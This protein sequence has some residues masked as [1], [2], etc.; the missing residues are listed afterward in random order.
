MSHGGQGNQGT[1]LRDVFDILVK[2]PMERLLSLKIQLGETPED[3]IIHALC[4]IIL[5]KEAQALEKLQMLKN[6][7][8]AEHLAEKWRMSGGK[9]EDFR[10]HCGHFEEFTGESLAA[11]ARIFKVLHERK[12]CDPNL[13]NLAYQRALSTDSQRTSH[14]EDLEYDPLR[15][16][17]KVVCGPEFE[18]WICSPRDL[19]SGSYHDPHRS[20]DE[21]N[22]TLKI[23]DQSE[24]AYSLP[25]PLQASSSMLSYPTHLEMSIP[26]TISFQGDKITPE[27]S[28][29]SDSCILFAPGQPQSSEEPQPKSNELAQLEANKDSKMESRKCDHHIIQNMTPN[30]TTKPSTEPKFA[31]PT[32][33]NTFV[34]KVPVPNEK[35]EC[36]DTEVEEEV[37]F[38]AFVILHAP[39][40]VDMAESIKDKIEAVAGCTGATF[41]EDFAVPGKSTLRCVEDA[42]NNSA[43]TLLLFTRNF[44]TQ[45]VEM[46]TDTALV[47]SINKKYKHNTVVPLLPR[48]NC[49]PREG[50]PL[51]VQRLNPLDEKRNFEKKIKKFLIPAHIERQKK[52][53]TKGQEVNRQIERQDNL[54]QLNECQRQLIQE[55][56]KAELEEREN[57]NLSLQQNLLLGPEQGGGGGMARWQQQPG[58]IHITNANYVM[59]GNDSKMN[60]DHRGHTDK[61]N[62]CSSEE[63]Q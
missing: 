45:L 6:N 4:L 32:A 3:N 55:C 50:I 39:E 25:S 52:I 5:H 56:K 49:M 34:P 10:V 27:T 60:V 12:L 61:D 44:N 58:H 51:V 41:S 29:K 36:K 7:Y 21:V 8:L 13:R 40:D 16:E 43:F 47:N 35:H 30:T 53:W 38:Y 24:R 9:L 31:L 57:L 48:E 37:V 54:K 33:T 19:K 62:S 26:P 1:G 20:L 11:L 18:E 46:K 28:D 23:T 2:E 14:L 17:A 63:E 42:I 59:V 15:E 22:T